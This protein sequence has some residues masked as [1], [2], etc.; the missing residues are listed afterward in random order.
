[1][2]SDIC[3]GV[4]LAPVQAA[5]GGRVNE[6]VIGTDPDPVDVEIRRPDRVDHLCRDRATL[7]PLHAVGVGANALRHLPRLARQVRADL[8]PVHPPS[9]DFHST[10]FA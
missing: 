9:S 1:M 7:A 6:A 5:I 2:K 8:R 3:G 4:T 10:L